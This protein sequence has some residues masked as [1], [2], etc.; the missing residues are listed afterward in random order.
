MEIKFYD[1]FRQFINI[2]M[3]KAGLGNGVAAAG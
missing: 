2:H 3:G 1:G